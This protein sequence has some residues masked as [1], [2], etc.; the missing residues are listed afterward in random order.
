MV[1]NEVFSKKTGSSVNIAKER[2]KLVLITDKIGCSPQIME[3]MKEDILMT[4]S[5]YVEISKNNFTLTITNAC[6][7]NDS[8]NMPVIVA[9]MPI[10]QTNTGEQYV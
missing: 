9:N 3:Q 1:I 5:K 2:L 10:K 8:H 4:V 6:M 7:D